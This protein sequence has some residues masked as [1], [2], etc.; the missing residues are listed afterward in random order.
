MKKR[1]Q[2]IFFII[3]MLA[4]IA[5]LGY[6]AL[7]RID[8]PYATAPEPTPT[9]T[10]TATPTP[11]PAPT[12]EPTEAP[13]EFTEAPEGYF[14]NALLIGDSRMEGIELECS[15]LEL[16]N[17]DFFDK[18][19]SGAYTIFSVLKEVD[20][21]ELNLSSLLNYHHYDKVYIMLGINDLYHSV[22]ECFKE[23]Q[24]LFDRVCET[25]PDAIIYVMANLRVT[26]DHYDSENVFTNDKI[27][28]LNEKIASLADDETVFYLD[29]NPIFDDGF[30]NLSSYCAGDSIHLNGSNDI[31]FAEW[32]CRNVIVK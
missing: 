13:L 5:A 17:A 3:I 12:P 24:K 16:Q 31:K 10:T 14:D 27:N 1:L 2:T 26:A 21:S 28:A 20:G 15:G 30:G 9:P 8:A 18:S 32:I 11:T 4:L 22:D 25:Q 6:I 7:I 29:A 23:Y 19:G